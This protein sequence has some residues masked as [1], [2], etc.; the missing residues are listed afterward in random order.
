[1]HYAGWKNTTPSGQLPAYLVSIG[2]DAGD[3]SNVARSI[4]KIMEVPTCARRLAEEARKRVSHSFDLKRQFQE[5]RQL[6]LSSGMGT[7][8][9]TRLRM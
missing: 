3:Y 6:I 5:I 2:I 1:M 4:S 7:T 8:T 9:Q